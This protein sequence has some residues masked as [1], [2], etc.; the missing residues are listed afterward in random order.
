[1]YK[2]IKRILI[3]VTAIILCSANTALA[4]SPEQKAIFNGG[5]FYFDH[6]TGTCNPTQ[7]MT[8]IKSVYILGDSITVGAEIAYK[9]KLTEKDIANISI[10]GA[11]SRSWKGGGLGNPTTDGSLASGK[12]AVEADSLKIQSAQVIVIALGTNGGL[13]SNPIEEMIGAIRAKNNTARIWW[14]NT[15]GTT[16]WPRDITYLGDFNRKL[17]E[18]APMSN[19]QVINWNNTVNPSGDPTVSPTTDVNNIL[20]DGLHP[21]ADGQNKLSDLVVN[22]VASFAPLNSDTTNDDCSCTAGAGGVGNVGPISMVAS[23]KIPEPHKSIILRAATKYSVNPNFIA[24]LFL[25]EQGNV[26]KSVNGPWASSNKGA[27]G[28]FQFMPG[29]W[30]QYKQDGNDDG[31]MDV[32]NF[33]DAAFA[34]AKLAGTGT[35]QSTPL[36]DLSKPFVPNT[37][38]Y[39]SAAYNWGGGNLQNKTN[40]NSPLS[41]S[42]EETQEYMK[43]IFMLLSSDFTKAG[44]KNYS[45]PRLPGQNTNNTTGGNL[46]LNSGC[47]S[48]GS[49]I[50]NLVTTDPE[51]ARNI[52]LSSSK[53][54]WGNYGSADSQKVDVRSCLTAA[55][56]LSFAT[57]AQNS[58]V[59]L[60][61]NALATDHGGCNNSGGSYHNKGRAIDIGYYGNN[62]AGSTKHKPE[63]DQLYK[64]LFDNREIL[65]IDELIWQY[66]PTGFKCMD[67]GVVGE[68]DT[69]YSADTLSQHYHHIHVSFKS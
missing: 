31:I 7:S 15:A 53:I 33:E 26:W 55:T 34:A 14:I 8:N 27:S 43:N 57:I 35:N 22:N 6:E 42:P 19:F 39:F 24:A 66:P 49:N 67:R 37:L 64:F 23:D 45:D 59:G 29:T 21:N 56:L 61:I 13:A 69:I 32:M 25:S 40:P 68:C 5:I 48:S 58:P 60:P 51:A 41:A 50:A 52:I 30:G 44:H 11:N 3:T 12:D 9:Q 46:S 65:Q 1:M 2:T 10:N 47:V 38:I 62:S 20:S 18:L 54:S 17:T 16:K 4:L 28:P 36:G 63:G